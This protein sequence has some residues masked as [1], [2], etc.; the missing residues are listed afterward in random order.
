MN[1]VVLLHIAHW[2]GILS[3]APRLSVGRSG[4]LFDS[5]HKRKRH[6]TPV[7][8][9]LDAVVNYSAKISKNSPK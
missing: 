9:E 8:L 5:M 7:T 3:V 4:H 6:I 2:E 1:H